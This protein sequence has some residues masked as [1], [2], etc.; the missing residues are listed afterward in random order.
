MHSF[1]LSLTLLTSAIHLSKAIALPTSL[2]SLKTRSNIKLLISNDD[3]W[4]EANYRRAYITYVARGYDVSIGM[5]EIR[6]PDV[7]CNAFRWWLPQR[8]TI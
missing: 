8:P 5:Y 7:I 4:A 2:K 1:I 3:G 6:L